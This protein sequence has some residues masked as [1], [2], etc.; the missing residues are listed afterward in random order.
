[1][2]N[3]NYY[4][5]LRGGRPFTTTNSSLASA[6]RILNHHLFGSSSGPRHYTGTSTESKLSLS[7]DSID[8]EGVPFID[9]QRVSKSILKKSESSNNYYSNAGDSDTE[10]LITDNASTI[11]MCDNETSTC[12]VFS[13]ANGTRVKP[14]SPLLSR[15]VLD[16]IFRTNNNLERENEV[17][18]T[19]EKN[20]VS[21]MSRS[22]FDDVLE[23]EKQVQDE[24]TAENKNKEE[25][26]KSKGRT[27]ES[28][29]DG[30]TMLICSLRS[31]KAK[32]SGGEERRKAK[33]SG[34][35]YKATDT[36]CLPQESRFSS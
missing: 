7:A 28:S 2:E 27:E 18:P 13:N 15:Q 1:M 5:G 3:N 8:S 24:A 21:K 4:G 10:K 35:A 17:D 23:E 33:N 32:K 16:S 34:H 20:C 19:E 29:K 6:T 25:R 12:S 31:H 22:I 14:V 26:R 36:N 11:S 9:R 30:Q